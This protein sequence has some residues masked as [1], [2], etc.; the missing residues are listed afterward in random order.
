MELSELKTP[1]QFCVEKLS[2]TEKCFLEYI[3]KQLNDD[4]YGSVCIKYPDSTKFLNVDPVIRV[5]RL[6]GW[7]V[8]DNV[9]GEFQVSID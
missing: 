9:F 3:M 7:K 2:D 4:S 8:T 5:L 6:L 1:L